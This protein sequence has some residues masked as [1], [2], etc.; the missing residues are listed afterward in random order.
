MCPLLRGFIDW[1]TCLS[2]YSGS[3][4][5]TSN[6]T[7]EHILQFKNINNIHRNFSNHYFHT[8]HF[9]PFLWSVHSK[10]SKH[11]LPKYSLTYS[12]LL[13]LLWSAVC[14][15]SSQLLITAV[16]WTVLRYGCWPT[17]CFLHLQA[18][19]SKGDSLAT[20]CLRLKSTY[21]N[22]F[23]FALLYSTIWYFTS[24]LGI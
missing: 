6:A 7:H 16:F 21:L 15:C 4:L 22:H 18:F 13:S 10:L 23:V 3:S 11:I 24:M 19:N 5:F 2:L 8:F 14:V 1:K 12:L 9:C 20:H 17:H